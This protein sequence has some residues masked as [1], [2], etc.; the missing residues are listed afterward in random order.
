VPEAY[1]LPGGGTVT[2]PWVSTR[3]LLIVSAIAAIAI[4]L[5]GAIWL[6]ELIG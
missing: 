2:L 3:F 1:P 4:V 6:L 5:A